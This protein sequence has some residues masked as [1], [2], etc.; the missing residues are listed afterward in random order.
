MTIRT[1]SN[2]EAIYLTPT[3]TWPDNTTQEISPEDLRNGVKDLF[4]SQN[5]YWNLDY[6]RDNGYL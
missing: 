3:G 4:E 1:K 5:S 2:F 6:L